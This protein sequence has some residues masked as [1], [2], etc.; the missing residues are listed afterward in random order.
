MQVAPAAA[1]PDAICAALD[2]WLL[3]RLSTRGTTCTTAAFERACAVLAATGSVSR[4]AAEVGVSVR[5]LERWCASLVGHA[6]Q[7]LAG[8]AR[9][10]RSLHAVQAGRGEPRDD[11]A[12]QAHQI[13][14]WR[15][16]LGTTPGRYRPSD[17][18][19][20]SI[21]GLAHFL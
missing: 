1:R 11:F 19:P 18:S 15:R 10:Q 6:P 12:D 4:A 9:V 21:P 3:P 20:I 2:A 7:T 17:M 13:R 5:Q 8:I 14:T 16:R